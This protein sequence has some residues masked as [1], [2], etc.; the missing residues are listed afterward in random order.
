[1]KKLVLR[2]PVIAVTGSSGKTTTKEMIAAI[3][4]RRW[5]IFKSPENSNLSEHISQYAK[6]IHPSHRALVLEYGM[7]ARGHLRRSCKIIQPNIT[8]ITMIGTAHIGNVGGTVEGLIRAKSEI[9]LNM[10]QA[11]TLFLNADDVNSRRLNTR[12]FQEIIVKIGINNEADYQAF[13]VRSTQQGMNFGVKLLDTYHKF[14]IPIL[15]TH[16]VYN[17]LFAIAVSN[18]L[19]FSPKQ[20]KEGLKN[21]RRLGGRLRVYRLENSV[22]L[23]DDTF[24]AN[25][26]S[27]K[28]AINVLTTIS[29]DNNIIVL[30]SMSELG[31]YYKRGHQEVGRYLADKN[32]TYLFTFGIGAKIIGEE[33]ISHGFPSERVIHSI[34]R[35]TLHQRLKRTINPGSTVLVKGSHNMMM[36]KTVKFLK[37]RT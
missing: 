13:D 34:Y 14:F 21:Y 16:N 29:K 6:Q 20:I 33:A 5:K 15:G 30:G 28:A 35:N 23:I 1:L 10:N 24:N 17:A 8:V 27:V 26:N 18:R 2:K 25:P 32:I 31:R 11:G 36:N 4:Q 3:L 22:C 37:R 19:G 7:F 12:K 9:I